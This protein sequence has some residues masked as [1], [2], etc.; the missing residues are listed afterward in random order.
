MLRSRRFRSASSATSRAR[1]SRSAS[2]QLESAVRAV[3]DDLAKAL[4]SE[5]GD[6][7]KLSIQRRDCILITLTSAR[8]P[9]Q[10]PCSPLRRSGAAAADARV[11]VGDTTASFRVHCLRRCQHPLQ[12]QVTQYQRASRLS[13]PAPDQ[14]QALQTAVNA[15]PQGNAHRA[16][17]ANP[18]TDNRQNA[19]A[20]WKAAT[21]LQRN[22]ASSAIRLPAPQPAIP[23]WRSIGGD[24]RR[25]TRRSLFAA[26]T[27]A[28]RGCA[29]RGEPNTTPAQRQCAAASQPP[30]AAASPAAAPAPGR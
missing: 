12:G 21:A 11:G 19:A 24:D 17:P 30:P 4:L 5:P 16:G 13:A 10:P 14:D 7:T 23:Q 22:V 3:Q 15:I 20:S 6:D 18:A 28:S 26:P 9:P 1:A 25:R 2:G 29:C 8:S 27:V